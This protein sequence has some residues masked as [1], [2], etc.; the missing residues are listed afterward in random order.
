MPVGAGEPV[1][2]TVTVA[3][4]QTSVVPV[5]TSIAAATGPGGRP[6]LTCSIV[7]RSVP[8]STVSRISAGIRPELRTRSDSVSR[9]GAVA[10]RRSSTTAGSAVVSATPR[11]T[12]RNSARSAP[13]SP[14]ETGAG[15]PPS[16]ETDSRARA[17]RS[18]W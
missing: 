13:S 14:P 3:S 12:V 10:R 7:A 2:R 17:R 1:S 11:S 8:A 4:V 6:A 18:P 9:P 16:A 15:G 5:A